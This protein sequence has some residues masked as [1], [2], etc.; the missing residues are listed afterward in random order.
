MIRRLRASTPSP[1]ARTPCWAAVLLVAGCAA[2]PP[3]G[4]PLSAEDR[5]AVQSAWE[6]ILAAEAAL[7]WDALSAHLT[8]DFVHLD[9]RSTPL[10]GRAAWRTWLDGMQFGD[11]TVSYEVQEIG[12]SGDMAYVWWTMNGNWTEGGQP[13]QTSAKGLTVFRKQADGGWLAARNAWNANP[14]PPAPPAPPAARR[15]GN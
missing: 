5:A 11:A 15:R 8:E 12:G 14:P 9:P 13:R 2:P 4:G 6:G 7:D 3:A 10:S 1:S